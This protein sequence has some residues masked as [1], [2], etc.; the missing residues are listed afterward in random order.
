MTSKLKENICGFRVEAVGGHNVAVEGT[1]NDTGEVWLR[2][3]K[4]RKAWKLS[5]EGLHELARAVS[6]AQ[7]YAIR[8]GFTK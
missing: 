7:I 4:G 6:R 5:V 3:G 1:V 2:M 8:E